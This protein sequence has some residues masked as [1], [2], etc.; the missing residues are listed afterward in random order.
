MDKEIKKSTKPAKKTSTKKVEDL[1]KETAKVAEQ[2]KKRCRKKLKKDS[3]KKS[4]YCQ[5]KKQ[6]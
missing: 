6:R 1:K 3:C 5:K 4:K 2:I